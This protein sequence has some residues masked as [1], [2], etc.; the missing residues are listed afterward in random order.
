MPDSYLPEVLVLSILE[1]HALQ[2]I[3]SLIR[4]LFGIQRAIHLLEAFRI[5]L[6]STYRRAAALRMRSFQLHSQNDVRENKMT[7]V[8]NVLA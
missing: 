8:V 7:S 5:L 4:N 2:V 6:N 1:Y 3:A